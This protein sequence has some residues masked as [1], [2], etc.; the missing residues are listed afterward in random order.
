MKKIKR[1]SLA[2]KVALFF[3]LVI[4]FGGIG[5]YFSANQIR[6]KE[7]LSS[8][9]HLSYFAEALLQ[10]SEEWHGI[11]VQKTKGLKEVAQVNGV[12]QETNDEVDLYRLHDPEVLTFLA[13]L[14]KSEAINFDL[15]FGLPGPAQEK[16]AFQ[17]DR[18][19]YE[20]PLVV[21]K[22]CVSCHELGKGAPP[23]RLGEAVGTIKI[24]F[25]NQSLWALL[26][27]SVSL[28]GAVAFLLVTLFLYGLVRFE[29]LTPLANL[30]QKVR[31]MSL[32]N[33]DIDL[34]V[35]DLSEDQIRDEILKLA[36]S[37]ERLRKSQKTMEKMLD[38][39]SLVL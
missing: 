15:S 10:A 12:S 9:R 36:I 6:Q 23:L 19:V 35:R 32:G 3:L 21:R 2:D 24:T 18:F 4:A 22:S 14:T 29:L 27:Q 38:D 25:H 13:S 17:K 37:I 7:L 5:I 28:W 26:G 31:E 30:T 11:W 33:L 16:W 20:K 1:L 39:D 34:G 8:A